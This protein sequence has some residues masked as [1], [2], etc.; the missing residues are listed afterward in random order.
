MISFISADVI[1]LYVK[2]LKNFD[3]NTSNH[4]TVSIDIMAGSPDYLSGNRSAS[5]DE[6]FTGD[7]SF[8]DSLSIVLLGALFGVAC[9]LSVVFGR[10]ALHIRLLA[11]ERAYAA[12]SQDDSIAIASKG[13]TIQPDLR[14]GHSTRS[15]S[16]SNRIVEQ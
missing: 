7:N 14:V 6:E 15:L 1:A 2:D 12:V 4:P 8:I 5:F 3:E 9:G 13:I 10:R 16:Q 11:S